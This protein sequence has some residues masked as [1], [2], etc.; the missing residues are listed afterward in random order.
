[1]RVALAT[2]NEGKRAELASL[3]DSLNI[4]LVTPSAAVLQGIDES[5]L[6]FIENA[7]IKARAV[8]ART[9]LPAIADDSGLSVNALDGKPGVHSARYAG[10]PS[11]AA[12]N[13]QK[14]LDALKD[15][16]DDQRSASF[17]CALVYLRYP[18][19]PIPFIGVGTWD[20]EILRA[21]RGC[22]GFGYD[23]LFFLPDLNKTAAELTTLE[24]NAISHRA[25]AAEQLFSQLQNI[26]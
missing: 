26:R 10:L 16:P 13:N 25:Q 2:S 9:E 12:R 19:D 15:T 21:P 6:T 11:N 20:G 17:Q 24:K 22:E 3:F 14:L 7:L 4:E 1:M 18:N 23:P 5:G 8:S